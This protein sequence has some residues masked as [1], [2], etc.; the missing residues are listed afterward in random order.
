[1]ELVHYQKK[2]YVMY[3]SYFQ[4]DITRAFHFLVT[5]AG[6]KTSTRKPGLGLNYNPAPVLNITNRSRKS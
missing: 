2:R 5:F 3:A 4:K 6:T 1:M